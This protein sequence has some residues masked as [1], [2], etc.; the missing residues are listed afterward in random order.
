MQTLSGKIDPSLLVSKYLNHLDLSMNDF[1]GSRI[2]SFIGSLQSLRYLNLSGASFGGTIPPSLGNLSRLIYLDLNKVDRFELTKSSLYWLSGLS[3]LKYLHLGGWDMSM[4]ATTKSSLLVVQIKRLVYLDLNS[5]YLYG[6]LPDKIA[7]LASLENLDFSLSSIEGQLSKK[8][9]NLCN[10]QS[11]KLSQNKITG[12]IT[13]VFDTLST[14]SRSNSETLNLGYNELTGN[15]PN[16][17]GYLKSLRY[18][19]MPYHLFQGSL[20]RSNGNLSALEQISL[21]NNKLTGIL[22]SLG[23]LSKLTVLDIS[24]NMWEGV[25]TETHLANLSSLKE[26]TMDKAS[27]NISLVFDISSDWIPP[28]KVTYL[29]SKSSRVGA[30]FPT[31]LKNQS[32]LSY[33]LDRLDIAYN[34]LS[35]GVPNSFRFNKESIAKF[36]P[37]PLWSSNVT[38][39]YL[40][41]NQFS[42]PIPPNMGEVMPLLTDLDASYNSLSGSIALSTGNITGLMNLVIFNNELS[43]QTSNIWENKQFIYI[44]D[45]SNN[46][47][48]GTIP[49]MGYLSFLGFLIY[50]KASSLDRRELHNLLILH[51]RSNSFSGNIPHQF[52]GLSKLHMVDLSHNHLTGHIPHCIGNLSGL[53]SEVQIPSSIGDFEW[54][55]TLDISMNHISSTIP[56]SMSS[57]TFL[58]HLNLSYNNLSGKIPTANQFLTLDDPS[59]YQGNAGICGRPLSTDCPDSDQSKLGGDGED[60]D[61]DG[62]DKFKKLGFIISIVIGFFVGL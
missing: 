37:L 1:G 34:Q 10:L 57:L 2:L 30:R 53:K 54:I 33:V 15:L 36:G 21:S 62:G 35:G 60:R 13:N 24:E 43:G 44:V 27:P 26:L 9:G 32:D 18:L 17:L 46:N 48:S 39:L 38:K 59:I 12:E 56:L 29:L 58:N 42:G 14:F 47:I 23:H 52:C 25:I 6:P 51:L 20:P 19:Q 7:S 3:S 55:E 28:F 41:D 61:G 11:L 4:S 31:W 45:M 49:T 16:S 40:R 5:N 22:K 8:L 50:R